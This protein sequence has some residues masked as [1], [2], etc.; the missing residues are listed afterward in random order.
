MLIP[1]IK[2]T[3]HNRFDLH[4]KV[5]DSSLLIPCSNTIFLGN[6]FVNIDFHMCLFLIDAPID[7][8]NTE[9][10]ICLRT[11]LEKMILSY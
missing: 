2:V 11:G 7:I 1:Y 4:H 9:S 5:I 3:Y 8:S 6:N 10:Y